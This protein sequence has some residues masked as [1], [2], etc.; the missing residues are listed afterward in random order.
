M[1]APPALER[2][3]W[4][5]YAKTNTAEYVRYHD[6]EWGRPV[7]D[8]LALWQ[9]LILDGMQ[10]GLSWAVILNKRDTIYEAFDGLK[11]R[12]IIH[13]DGRD[14]E[15]LLSN[16]GIIRSKLK[17]ASVISNAKAYLD[18]EDE[19]SEFIWSFTGGVQI[20]N[21]WTDVAAVPTQTSESQAMSKALKKRGFKFVGPT[22][23]YAFMQAVG[24]VN[25]HEVKCHAYSDCIER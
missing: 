19:F 18:M 11:P 24:I 7:R 2:C 20:V 17:C 15:R 4:S 25:D 3:D 23:C 5:G 8:G 21:R 1:T 9:K 6:E 14:M 12:K 22:I 10:A 13:Y 16:P